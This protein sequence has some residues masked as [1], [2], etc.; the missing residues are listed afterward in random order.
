MKR[1]CHASPRRIAFIGLLVA[2]AFV[3]SWLEV[4]LPLPVGIP[5]VKLG[6]CHI[7]VVFALFRLGKRYA[8]LITSVR[9]LL[10]SLLFGQIVSALYSMAGAVISLG[11]MILLTLPHRS[12]Q[13]GESL[14]SPMGISVVGGVAHNIAQL[15]CASL[16]METPRLAWYLPVLL[17]A[18]CI[19]GCVV[20]LVS[21]LI[22][23]RL[24]GGMSFTGERDH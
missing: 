23:R 11:M 2:V 22:L 10:S 18:G 9:V 16:L 7:V 20:G 14:F 21:I 4:M 17:F 8:F 24:P 5:G 13:N 19:S 6:L 1:T 3:L 15:T 12:G